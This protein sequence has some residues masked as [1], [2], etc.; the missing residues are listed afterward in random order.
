MFE[1]TL[2]IAF[3][4]LNANGL[5]AAVPLLTKWLGWL[6][7]GL[8]VAAGLGFVVFV[9]ELGH[10]LAAKTF[11]VRCDKFYIGFDVP[12]SIGPIRLPP[13]LGRFRWG[14]TEY[15]IG[16]IPL[17]GYVKML[18]QED[19]PRKAEEEE[20]RSRMGEGPNAPH[21]PRSYKAKPVW[22]R[23][24]IISAGVV[25]NVIFAVFLAAGA[26]LYGAPYMPTIVGSSPLGAPAW[27]AGLLPGDS[28]VQVGNMTKDDP[29][30]RFTDMA[31]K[32]AFHGMK[33][34]D[35]PIPFTIERDGQRMTI[36]IRPSKKVSPDGDFYLAGIASATIAELGNKSP[37]APY[38]YLAT[39]KVDLQPGDRIVAVDGQ[40]LTVN[41]AA[42]K[43]LSAPVTSAFQAKWDK[44]V[45]LTVLR[46]EKAPEGQTADPASPPKE[47]EVNVTLPPV[48]VKS[49]GLGFAIGPI[50]AIRTGSLAEAAGIKAG[51]VIESVDG[52]PVVDAL[53]LPMD[54]AKK[55]GKPIEFKVRRE[56]NQE[57]LSFT[58]TGQEPVSFGAI[59][60]F[61]GEWG[62]DNYGIAYEVTPKVSYVDPDSEKAAAG[63]KVGDQL[64]QLKLEL[65]PAEIEQYAENGQELSD[66]VHELTAQ[67]TM[68][69]YFAWLQQMPPD[70]KVRCYLKR[71]EEVR[72]VVLPLHYVRDWFWV[73]RGILLKRLDKIQQTNNLGQALSWGAVETVRRLGDVFEFLTIL[74]TGRASARNLAGPVGI[75]QIAAGEAS[76][77]PSRLLLFLTMLSA[78]LAILNFLPIPVLDGGHIMFLTAEAVLGKP[79]NQTLQD[80]LTAAGMFALLGL[81][82]FALLNDIL[83]NVM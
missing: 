47:H 15:G 30:L 1:S 44:P 11:G 79:L 5:L 40:R 68:A 48:P 46:A 27:Q 2:T 32:T 24:I 83:R 75:A 37:I 72:E 26:F 38:S 70:V 54:V 42:G 33:H 57:L 36:N 74:V 21:D 66:E 3:E 50:T 22:Q 20:A 18:G 82:A 13:R 19:D 23:M 64:T 49:L 77:S 60:D 53:R 45:E 31:Q 12:L 4:L 10:F 81:M 55:I 78:N 61:G 28:I 59:G 25:M 35:A 67:N 63:V 71:N 76:A 56:G 80:R 51:D 34:Q 62:L 52:E 43:V 39:E 58:M 29:Y 9:H 16:I 41:E 7:V 6:V 65:T 17:G 8:E 73:Q 14:E 69:F